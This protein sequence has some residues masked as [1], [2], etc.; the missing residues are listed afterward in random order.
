MKTP[1]K[2][3]AVALLCVAMTTPAAAAAPDAT[4][5]GASRSVQGEAVITMRLD[6]EISVNPQGGVHDYKIRT[7]VTP[8]VRQLLDRVIPAWKFEPV[9][10]DGRPV[11]ARSPMRVVVA[12]RQNKGGLSIWIENAIFR[13]NTS[14]EFAEDLA[15]REA[16]DGFRIRSER[17]NPPGYPA[18]LMR[19]GVEGIVLLNVLVGRDGRVADVIAEQSSLLNVKGTP[20][21]LEPARALLERVSVLNA[22][23]WRFRV[24]GADPAALDADDL[25]LRIPVEFRMG[26]GRVAQELTGTWRYEYR[27]PARTPPWLKGDRDAMVV[28]VSDLSSGEM[29][30]GRPSLRLLDREQALAPAA[31]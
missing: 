18:E 31:L 20:G 2:A 29:L 23:H 22:R 27:G 30:S 10:V 24:E 3:I 16:A 9:L 1:G 15:L 21:R 7:D 19:E 6:G 5:R 13:P 28:G 25:T 4:A 14:E 8:G 26:N 12:A 17:M 11:I